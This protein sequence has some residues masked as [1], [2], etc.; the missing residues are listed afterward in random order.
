[1]RTLLEAQCR[2][3][4]GGSDPKYAEIAI[5]SSSDKFATAGFMGAEFVPALEPFCMLMSCRAR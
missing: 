5:T 1:M 4:R 2:T 3:Q